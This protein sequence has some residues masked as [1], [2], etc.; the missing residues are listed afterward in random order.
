LTRQSSLLTAFTACHSSPVASLTS[1]E[2]RPA[3]FR[4]CHRYPG[5][6]LGAHKSVR[7]RHVHRLSSLRGAQRP[8]AETLSQVRTTPARA[9]KRSHEGAVSRGY[10]NRSWTPRRGGA[11]AS[12]SEPE[13]ALCHNS[14]CLCELASPPFASRT[15]PLTLERLIGSLSKLS[16]ENAG[17]WASRTGATDT[18]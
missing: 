10:A 15:F 12:E 7:P 17:K 3:Q 2:V 14:L 13:W 9:R 5:R 11:H 16:R 1:H 6:R 8:A 18:P 4:A